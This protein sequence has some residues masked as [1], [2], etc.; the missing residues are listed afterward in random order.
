[1]TDPRLKSEQMVVSAP[2]S[3]HG[4]TART[5][6]LT[7]LGPQPWSKVATIPAAVVILVVWWAAIVVW[8]IFF[9]ILVIPYRL[10]RRGSRKRKVEEQRHREQ[11]AAQSR[12]GDA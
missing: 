8:Y 2:M 11:L 6:K 9:G 7:R 10:I 1:V 5:W 4:A 3:F 12:G